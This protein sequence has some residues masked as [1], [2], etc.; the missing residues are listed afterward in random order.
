MA[1]Q[2]DVTAPGLRRYSN[3]G[4]D[5]VRRAWDWLWDFSTRKPLGGIGLFFLFVL[6]IIVFFGPQIARALAPSAATASVNQPPWL[7]INPRALFQ[8]PEWVSG[9]LL[10]ADHLGRDN[11]SRLLVGART[12]LSV[13]VISVMSGT[14]VG[15]TMGLVSGYYP[16]WRDSLIQRFVDIK[17]AFPTIVLALAI[18][19][20][21][22]QSTRNVIIA[23][24]LIQ[25]PGT[26]RIV[27]SVVL[28]TRTMEF[29]QAARAL[30][31]NDLRILFR[32]I[33]PQTFAPVMIIMTAGF[34]LA[35]IIESSLS[36]LGLG[37]PPP[38]PAWG[39]M[40]SGPTLQNVERAPW[41]AV[42][43]G[44]AITFTVFSFNLVG[45]SL[46]DILDP[47]LRI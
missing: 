32:H 26:A 4:L 39:A 13:S 46:R 36:F 12:S 27:R 35:I 22:G 42:F 41:N 6:T 1:T 20:V 3:A 24:S 38:N 47:R 15:F 44:L 37:T 25:V 10:G 5:V 16:G 11:L 33:A 18:V 14:A 7:T 34:G 9:Y 8:S 28:S 17:M 19:A 43:P 40:L 23:I 30:G 29:V 2:A 21:L 45:D 31:A